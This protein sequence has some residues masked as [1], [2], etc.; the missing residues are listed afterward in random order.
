[1]Q[2]STDEY[3]TSIWLS[4]IMSSKTTNSKSNS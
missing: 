4:V 1:M 2:K 3:K